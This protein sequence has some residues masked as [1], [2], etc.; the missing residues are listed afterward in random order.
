MTVAKLSTKGQVVLP[1]AVRDARQWRPGTEFEV[2]EREDGVLLKPKPAKKRY[3]L[4]DLYGCLPYEGPP[5]T[6]EDMQRGIDEA[7]AERWKRKSGF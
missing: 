1:K 2:I 4:D 6:L 3:T 7:M 5:K